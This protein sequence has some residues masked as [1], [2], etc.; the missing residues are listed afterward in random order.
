[1]ELARQHNGF[2]IAGHGYDRHLLASVV[3]NAVRGRLGLTPEYFI[4]PEES[5]AAFLALWNDEDV[6]T[7]V[8]LDDVDDELFLSRV[9][10]EGKT[11]S[12]SRALVTT[13]PTATLRE[14]F[15]EIELGKVDQG[16][17]WQYL[18][19]CQTGGAF[20]GATVEQQASFGNPL[21]LQYLW[22]LSPLPLCGE[23]TRDRYSNLRRPTR[24]RPGTHLIRRTE[25]RQFAAF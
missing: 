11:L 10:R 6:P 21:F 12:S 7:L 2:Y 22:Q 9:L 13:S 3:V 25:R 5:F 14:G 16:L 15:K 17:A 1:M 24:R 8:Y 20:S 4:S 23:R 19:H 18:E